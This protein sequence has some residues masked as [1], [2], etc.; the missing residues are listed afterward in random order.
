MKNRVDPQAV[1]SPIDSSERGLGVVA[2]FDGSGGSLLAL[3]YAARA[4]RRRNSLLTV[5]TAFK[6]PAMIYTTYAALPADREDEMR[7]RVADDTLQQ[8]RA[9]LS[10]YPGEVSYRAVRGDAAGVMVEASA[11]A[12]LVVIGARGRGGFLSRLLGSVASAL[13]AHSHCPTVVVPRHYRGGNAEGR[14]KF[15][16]RNDDLPVVVGMDGSQH[17]RYAALA[18]AQAA[19]D[20][21]TSLHMLMALPSLERWLVWYPELDEADEHALKRRKTAIEA[22]LETD[23]QWLRSHFP[24]LEVT[25]SVASGDPIPIL[26]RA[27]G[28]A[29]LTVLGTRG[30][31][32]LASTLLGSVSKGTLLHARGPVMIVPEG[33][34]QRLE[35]HP[36]NSD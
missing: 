17:S 6:V 14:E 22:S 10:E 5:I 29:Q 24:Q 20:R 1:Q 19:Q 16:P 31:G 35:S 30:R 7:Q 28:E 23:A 26:E 13:P 27:S 15:Y 33:A 8:A 11:A 9:Y 4:A 2:G 12:D 34:D 21:S 32:G 3:N 18:A 36:E 25:A